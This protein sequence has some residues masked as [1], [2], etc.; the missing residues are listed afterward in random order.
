MTRRNSDEI[1][2]IKQFELFVNSKSIFLNSA[3]ER[4]IKAPVATLS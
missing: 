1:T 4:A 3:R 2:P